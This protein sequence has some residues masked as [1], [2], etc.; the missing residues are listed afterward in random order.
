MSLQWFHV[1]GCKGVGISAPVPAAISRVA[2]FVWEHFAAAGVHF[3]G[4]TAANCV[5]E[6]FGV[7]IMRAGRRRST[8]LAFDDIVKMSGEGMSSWVDVD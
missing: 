4:L 5:D 8:S 3:V 6:W 1:V 7:G 2:Q